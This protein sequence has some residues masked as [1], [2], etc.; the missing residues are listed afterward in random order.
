MTLSC[1]SCSALLKQ[2]LFSAFKPSPM[3]VGRARLFRPWRCRKKLLGPGRLRGKCR[4]VPISEEDRISH[5]ELPAALFSRGGC[6]CC[7]ERP[8]GSIQFYF[9][10]A[11]VFTTVFDSFRLGLQKCLWTSLSGHQHKPE[12]ELLRI[13]NLKPMPCRH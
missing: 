1:V 3:T 11:L 4:D 8:C 5:P 12:D 9:K 13:D 10:V 6:A 2:T 7:F